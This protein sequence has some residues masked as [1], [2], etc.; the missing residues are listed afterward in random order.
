M[1]LSKKA[2][3]CLCALMMS[4]S[5]AAVLGVNAAD[6]EEQAS[7]A[8]QTG[9]ADES[10]K[11]GKVTEVNSSELTVALGEFSKKKP[12]TESAEGEDSS[13]TD[14]KAGNSRKMKARKPG[15]RSET[16]TEA[17]SEA[18]SSEEKSGKKR[19]RKGRHHGKFTENG[20]T[21]T[22]SLTDDVTVTKKGK[23][24][25][26]SDISEGDI[27]KLKYDENGELTSVKVSSGH[28]QGRKAGKTSEADSTSDAEQGATA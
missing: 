11:V 1:K 12:R 17:D 26:V 22:V 10:V 15:T 20:T 25:E 28:K 2:A 24:A 8:V 3:A 16:G 21:E 13:G 4:V 6:I 27:V 5:S 7:A 18:Q 9:S 19:C 23:A 14:E